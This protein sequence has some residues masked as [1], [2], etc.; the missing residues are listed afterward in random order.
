MILSQPF[1]IIYIMNFMS[2][3]S[4]FFA[5]NNFKFYGIKKGLTDENYLAWL[6]SIAAV[7]NSIRFIWSFA[8]DYFSY[9]V[10]YGVLLLMQIGL[11]FSIPYISEN[12]SLYFLW[13]CLLLLC[14]GGHFTLVPN[15]LKKIYGEKGTLL[16]G[17]AFSYTGICSILLVVLQTFLLTSEARSYDIF[18]FVNGALS[19]L[20]LII[21]VLLFK[22]E[23]FIH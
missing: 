1:I 13:V 15:V 9:K 3:C 21:L 2:I 8:T 22:E 18:F 14:E 11:D 17:I 10:V 16:Y 23:K 4:G 7:C 20:A 6:G 5:V 12:A 19:I